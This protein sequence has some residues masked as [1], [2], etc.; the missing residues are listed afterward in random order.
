M[1][2]S[3]FGVSN[4]V[5]QSGA[6]SSIVVNRQLGDYDPSGS[7]TWTAKSGPVYPS[8]GD[9]LLLVVAGTF[10]GG[11]TS[12]PP[13]QVAQPPAGFTALFDNPVTNTSTGQVRGLWVFRRTA[14]SA[15]AAAG[16]Y[17]IPYSGTTPAG[18]RAVAFL[19]SVRPGAGESIQWDLSSG[20]QNNAAASRMNTPAASGGHA[21]DLVMRVLWALSSSQT[22]TSR[23][24]VKHDTPFDAASGGS[25]LTPAGVTA[26]EA[27]IFGYNLS[28]GRNAQAADG[29]AQ[30]RYLPL[31]KED[32]SAVTASNGVAV[33]AIAEAVSQT[34]PANTVQPTVSG[35]AVVGQTISVN[36]GTWSGFPA[37][38]FTYQWTRDGADIA[39]ATASTYTLVTADAGHTVRCRVTAD[40]GVGSPASATSSNGIAVPAAPVNTVAPAIPAPVPPAHPDSLYH[41]GDTLTVTSGTFSPTPDAITYQWYRG[42]SPLTGETANQYTLQVTDEGASISSHVTA[43]NGGGATTANSNTIVP[44]VTAA[45]SD[46][47]FLTYYS[48][49]AGNSDP[50]LSIGGARGGTMLDGLDE[51]FG[52]ILGTVAQAGGEF[53]RVVYVRNTHSVSTAAAMKLFIEQQF[54]H[55]G[56]HLAVAVP[57]VGANVAVPAL[58]S[59]T[60]APSGVTWITATDAASGADFGDLGPAA[61]RGVYVRLTVDAGTGPT[62][63]ADASI[64]VEGSAA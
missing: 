41:T 47:S 39:G 16:S 48:G 22:G 37:P 5:T 23:T 43:S 26:A 64:A 21:G 31:I 20:Q 8:V 10:G 17:T 28:V 2:A 59:G 56:L 7:G 52:P 18:A 62:S 29:T 38:S 6:A 11:N 13:G 33:T 9:E 45:I 57:S 30:Q 63:E 46:A 60:T 25:A 15:D 36:P 55:P 14:T 42:A 4:I 44:A 61:Y 3:V 51:L 53:Y 24:H 49:G 35:T 50:A 40:N 19:V 27:T 32:G 58:A 34:A 54:S 12:G 1:S